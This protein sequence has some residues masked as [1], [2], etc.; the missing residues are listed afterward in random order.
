MV[1]NYAARRATLKPPASRLQTSLNRPALWCREWWKKKLLKHFLPLGKTLRTSFRTCLLATWSV[2]GSWLGTP[3]LLAPAM[4]TIAAN[5]QTRETRSM[6][7]FAIN[8]GVC[9][10]FLLALLL[11]LTWP[12]LG[13]TI[14]SWKVG[15]HN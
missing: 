12:W 14:S 9:A 8:R 3:A 5:R 1:R 6:R 4:R 2:D 10:G 15:P 7:A 11:G 13:D